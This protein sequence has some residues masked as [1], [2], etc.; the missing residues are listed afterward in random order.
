M[1]WDGMG[2]DGMGWEALHSSAHH[3][4]CLLHPPGITSYCPC[5]ISPPQCQLTVPSLR[6]QPGAVPAPHTVPVLQTP[7][8]CRLP[9][10]P[11]PASSHPTTTLLVVILFLPASPLLQDMSLSL[12]EIKIWIKIC[13]YCSLSK[14]R[15]KGR[16][17]RGTQEI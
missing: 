10:G 8:L 3:K 11:P 14:S 16:I 15:L 12:R 1:G 17:F 2:W 6:G 9:H 5:R 13:L 4:I 7:G